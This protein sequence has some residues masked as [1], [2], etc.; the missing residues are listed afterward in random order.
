MTM[1]HQQFRHGDIIKS[2]AVRKGRF[3]REHYGRLIDIQLKVKVR[4]GKEEE[5]LCLSTKM[6]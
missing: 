5:L 4:M 3:T 1:P 2:L 6:M